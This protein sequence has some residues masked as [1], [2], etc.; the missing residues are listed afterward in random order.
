MTSTCRRRGVVRGSVP[1]EPRSP[2]PSSLRALVRGEPARTGGR[3]PGGAARPGGLRAGRGAGGPRAAPPAAAVQPPGSG[4]PS[5]RRARGAPG[6]GVRRRRAPCAR[7]SS[8]PG[9][10][11]PSQPE[12]RVPCGPR[13]GPRGQTFAWEAGRLGSWVTCPRGAAPSAPPAPGSAAAPAA[14]ETA[15]LWPGGQF[16]GW[17]YEGPRRSTATV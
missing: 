7:S 2:A 3:R 10:Q 12:L 11:E 6:S 13:E 17:R 16:L 4:F 8:D 15:Q 1:P 9:P 5:G 14:S